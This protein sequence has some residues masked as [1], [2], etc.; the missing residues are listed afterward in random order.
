M[1]VCQCLSVNSDMN[2][3]QSKDLLSNVDCRHH[4][5]INVD[6]DLLDLD[7]D[8]FMNLTRAINLSRK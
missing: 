7:S 8:D 2:R 4:I 1:V 3:Y 5:F 6:F